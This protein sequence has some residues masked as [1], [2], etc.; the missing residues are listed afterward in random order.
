MAADP[1]RQKKYGTVLP[2][3]KALSEETN[4]ASKRDAIIRRFPDPIS[5]TVFGQIVAAVNYT[6]IQAKTLNDADKAA[7]LKQIQDA[8][9]TREPVLEVELLKFFLKSFDELPANQ[10]FVPAEALFGSLKGSARLQAEAQFADSIVNGEYASPEA[11]AGLYG[12]RTTEYKPE[13]EKILTFAKGVAQERIA[14]AARGA[15]FNA[16]IDR[17]RSLYM[18]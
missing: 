6:Q 9:K 7:K 11:T 16:A 18:Q 12:V 4:A 3:L 5:G 10:K 2:E 17:L 14:L 8:Y 15:K 13:R 1:A